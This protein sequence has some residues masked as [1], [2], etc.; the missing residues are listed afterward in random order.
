MRDWRTITGQSASVTIVGPVFLRCGLF[1]L[2]LGAAAAGLCQLVDAAPYD[3][4][5]YS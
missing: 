1:L 5:W 2:V 4:W 3:S